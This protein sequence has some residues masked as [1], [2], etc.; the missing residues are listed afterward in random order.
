MQESQRSRFHKFISFLT[1]NFINTFVLAF[2]FGFCFSIGLCNANENLPDFRLDRM[3]GRNWAVLLLFTL[4]FYLVIQ[5]VHFFLDSIQ[6]K[7]TV[8]SLTKKQYWGLFAAMLLILLRYYAFLFVYNGPGSVA[9][10]TYNQLLQYAGKRTR[11]NDNPFLLTLL[12]G[13]LHT[14]G[15]RIGGVNGGIYLNLLVQVFVMAWAYVRSAFFVYEKT[16]SVKL[17]LA[18]WALYLILPVFGGQAQIWLKDSIH[19]GI[20]VLFFIEYIRMFSADIR[21]KT[22]TRFCILTLLTCMTRKATVLIVAVC[23]L[24]LGIRHFPR[25][26]KTEERKHPV[27]WVAVAGTLLL[28]I[29][30][31]NVLLPVFGVAPAAKKENYVVP[32]RVTSLVVRDHRAELSVDE[33][34]V[35][36]EFLDLSKLPDAY[37]PDNMDKVKAMLNDASEP[38]LNDLLKLDLRLFFRFPLTALQAVIEGSWRY[39]HPVLTDKSWIRIYITEEDTYGWYTENPTAKSRLYDWYTVFWEKTPVLT[40]FTDPGLYLWLVFFAFFRALRVRCKRAAVLIAPLVIFTLGLIVTPTNGDL[41]YA[42]PVICALPLTVA[43]FGR[44]SITFHS[45]KKLSGYQISDATAFDL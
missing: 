16:G 7:G 21:P 18:T 27:Y 41:R 10:D 19:S 38:Y 32:L 35:I 43:A 42:F 8:R 39:Y 26:R 23:V 12:Y 6:G 20:F 30:Y 3:S 14:V 28:F 31:E 36:S 13:W 25:T 40:M 33:T 11:R 1:S 24:I 29:L 34:K 4:F 5:C 44:Q 15:R 45:D 37:N 22:L 9:T 17:L 2:L